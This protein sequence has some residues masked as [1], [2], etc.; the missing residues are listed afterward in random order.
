MHND[1]MDTGYFSS[2]SL[3]YV[4]SVFIIILYLHTNYLFNCLDKRVDET[5][6]IKTRSKRGALS[7]ISNRATKLASNAMDAVTKLGNL[8][9]IM[10]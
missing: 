3:C 7:D 4:S 9:I 2:R 8:Y 1:V 10:I 5:S 6:G